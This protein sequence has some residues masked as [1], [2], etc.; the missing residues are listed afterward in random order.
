MKSF[1]LMLVAATALVSLPALAQ[2]RNPFAER[3]NRVAPVISY[4]QGKGIRFTS[5]GE[6]GGLNGYL[7]ENATGQQQVFYVT[8]DGKHVVVGV[9]VR[10]DGSMV[11]GI[12]LGE[13][14]ARFEAAAQAFN[15]EE[16]GAT[17]VLSE[18]DKAD[19]DAET[20]A[21]TDAA[22]SDEALETFLDGKK[23]EEGAPEGVSVEEAPTAD[24][25]IQEESAVL[26]PPADGPAVGAQ[27]NPSDMW[28]S[29]INKDEF[30]KKAEQLPFFEVGSLSAPATLWMVA[31]PQCPFCHRTWDAIKGSVLDRKLK[32]RVIMIAGLKGSD[33]IATNMLAHV[34]PARAWLDS[35]GG[36]N[37]QLTVSPDS[38][39]YQKAGEFL[40]RNMD[41][42][43]SMGF[44]R[45]PFLAYV[46]KD[47]QFYS[48]LGLPN[49]LPS[50][51]AQTGI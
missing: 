20:E 46:G 43:R 32:V 49:D 44:D 12:Q 9:M 22:S 36:R 8:P 39:E 37:M 21:K 6:A 10:Q 1:R 41:F 33:V 38:L 16:S 2:E 47:G 28:I 31:D 35:N 15:G 5:I 4:F 42:A 11:T 18:L 7:A 51:L 24:A 25:S 23:A 26:L 48:S 40:T 13:M 29:K 17:P 45:T 14:R 50:F 27:G 30:L 3:E 34:R 19:Q